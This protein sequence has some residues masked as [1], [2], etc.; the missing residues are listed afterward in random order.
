MKMLSNVASKGGA[1]SRV[2]AGLAVIVAALTLAA[3]GG[4]GGGGGGGT[5][6][7]VAKDAVVSVDST[8]PAQSATGVPIDTKPIMNFTVSVGTYNAQT[9]TLACGGGNVPG[10]STVSSGQLT[11]TPT[12]PLPYDVNCAFA[13]T[14]TA[15]GESGG[16]NATASWNVSFATEA[17]PILHYTDKLY[18]IWGG[19]GGYPQLTTLEGTRVPAVN[20]TSWPTLIGCWAADVKQSDGTVPV[21]CDDGAVR[22]DDL[23]L[24]PVTNELHQYA[25]A[26]TG[27]V[28][29]KGYDASRIPPGHPDWITVTV[30][31]QGQV[32]AR[33]D[34]TSVLRLL[35]TDG[36]ESVIVP[37][38][39]G[40]D[41]SIGYV[42]SYSN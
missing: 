6:P 16:K 32:F 9:S 41:G 22:H 35:A 11:F 28:W 37:G 19:N 33:Q 5:T 24:N 36:T 10:A 21:S 12:S 4:G 26:R 1:R 34:S 18:S 13:G 2:F 40:T 20:M 17:A 7:P 39:F 31:A 29:I 8:T 23:Y 3:C 14:V 25:V 15:K 30:V 27:I 38:V 42:V